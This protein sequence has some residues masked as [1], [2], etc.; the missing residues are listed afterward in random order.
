MIW[1]RQRVRPEWLVRVLGPGRPEV[2][3]EDCFA[4]LD[5]YVEVELSEED[6]DA[7][8][9]GLE[10]HLAGCPAC[11][12]EHALLLAYVREQG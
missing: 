10:A 3:C 12:D 11:R 8:F 6:A 5:E 9:P 2:S 7:R 1:N 4:L